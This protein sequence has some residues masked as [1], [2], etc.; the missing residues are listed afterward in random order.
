MQSSDKRRYARPNGGFT[1][2]GALVSFAAGLDVVGVKAIEDIS[3]KPSRMSA[4]RM[5]A[6][7][8]RSAMTVA[9]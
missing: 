9:L 3:S 2:D 8:C 6:F 1:Y 5:A 7:K 4:R